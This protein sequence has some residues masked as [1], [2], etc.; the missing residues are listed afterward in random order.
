MMARE[1]L[2]RNVLL[3]HNHRRRFP[4]IGGDVAIA[5]PA[6]IGFTEKAKYNG[7]DLTNKPFR[8]ASFA[9]YLNVFGGAPSI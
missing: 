3:I 9:E 5:I 7:R 1:P 8:I 6:F 4:G 2:L